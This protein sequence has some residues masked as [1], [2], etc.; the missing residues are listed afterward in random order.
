MKGFYLIFIFLF[1]IIASDTLAQRSN[2]LTLE[3]TVTVEQG[4]VEGAVIKMYRNGQLTGDYGIG[5][6]GRYRVELNYNNDFV[7]IF[8]RKDNFPQKIEVN[9]HVP[10]EVLQS[11]PLFPPFPVNVKLFTEIPRIDRTFSENTVQKIYYSDRVDNFISDLF[12]NEAQIK[13]LIDQAVLHSQQIGKEADNLEGLTRTELAEL[14]KEYDKLIKEAENEYN[15][16]EF[17]T[18]LD[19]YKAANKIF[20]K[21]QYPIDRID[22]INDL[23]GLLMVAGEMQKALTDRLQALLSQGDIMFEQKNYDEARASYQRALSVE[24]DN[25]HAQLRL[26]E[27]REIIESQQKN[28]EYNAL[29]VAADNSFDELLY[30]EARNLYVRALELKSGEI[31]PQQKI[32]EVDEVLKQQ[33]SNAEKLQGYRESIFQAELNYEKQ[34]YDKAISFYENALI[35]KPGDDAAIKKIEEIRVLMSQLANQTL[36]DKRIKTADRAFKREQFDEALVEYE[37]ASKL[38]PSEQYP[39]S[40]IQQINAMYAEK[41]RLAAEAA[42]AEQARLAAIE[43]TKELQYNQALSR[44]D[45]LFILNELENSRKS[46]QAALQIKPGEILPETRIREI[47]DLIV[48]HAAIQM[49]YEAAVSRGNDAFGNE[50]YEGAKTAYLEAL[51]VKPGEAYPRERLALIDSIIEE[52]QRLADESI[53]ETREHLAAEAE[54]ERLRLAAEAEAAELARLSA[55]EAAKEQQYMQAVSRADSLFT[56][57]EY[58][59]SRIAFQAASQIKPEE[60][61]PLQRIKQIDDLIG[62]M[63][64][65]Q[66][67]YDAALIRGDDA[68]NNELFEVAKAAYMEAMQAKPE[69]ILPLEMLAR[70]DSIVMTRERLAAEAEAER[71]RLTAEREAAEQARL[72]ALEAEK[73][74]QYLQVVNRADSLFEIKDYEYSLATYQTALQIKPQEPQ[75]EKRINEITELMAMLAASQQAYDVALLR[76]DNAFRLESYDEAKAAFKEAQLA[77]PEEQYPKEML[78]QIDSIIETRE[79]LAEEAEAERIRLAAEAEAA[80]K[81]RL[82]ALEAEKEQQYARA[83]ARADSLFELNEYENSHSTYEL[84]LQVKNDAVY[85]QQQIDKLNIILEDIKRARLEQEKM[86]IAFQNAINNA[87]Q[88]FDA[89]DYLQAKTGYEVALGFKP[90]D[91]YSKGRIAEL[92]RLMQQLELEEKYS[93]LILSADGFFQQESWEEAKEAYENALL[94]KPDESH[95]KGQLVK[96][97]NLLKQFENKAVAERQAAADMERRRSEIERRQQT[98]QERQEMNDAGLNQMYSE[99]ISLADGFFDTRN[100]N[101]SRAWYYKAS[102]I[103]QEEP[104]PKQRI[105]EIKRLVGSLLLNQRDR[106]YQQF[107]DLADSTFRDNQLAVSR[108][109]YNRALSIKPDESYPKEQLQAIADLIAERMA[110]RSGEQFESHMK[111]GAEAFEKQNY[112]VARYWYRQAL[113]LRP[114]SE[115]AKVKLVEIE[116]AVK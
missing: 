63:A 89:K 96:I 31:Y 104:Y 84:A 26:D 116:G 109:W 19:G 11:D 103:K 94:F 52:Q 67:A 35:H 1:T 7:L 85:P 73:E 17:L 64:A 59:D 50:S 105:E 21:E 51:Q 107:I 48:Q 92:D 13:Q 28:R 30:A 97:N 5:G 100:Y 60:N 82:A 115:E 40:Q 81:D 41:E 18:A 62:R 108:G 65:A 24:P 42:A 8:L 45:S 75:V 70:I 61:L 68:L 78:V 29:I 99:Y 112:N 16:E 76:G 69:E 101:V 32:K 33:A 87:D 56:V 44:A 12:Y 79:R 113:V 72:A 23:L 54:A 20:P 77:K 27:I 114:D 93:A 38:I 9:T 98:L 22:E 90:D 14:R 88:Q 6:N 110:G 34:F 46:Y 15:R 39:L 2:G 86:E 74:Q 58:N 83:L 10:R 71:I 25:N 95:P 36:Y 47:D 3:G 53:V 111:N 37:E 4:S 66:Q 49:E 57:K 106:D 55:L 43:A 102:D 91:V 80:E